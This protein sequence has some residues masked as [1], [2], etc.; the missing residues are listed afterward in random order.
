[1]TPRILLLLA[2]VLLVLPQTGLGKGPTVQL[3]IAGAHSEEPIH[4]K[5][6]VAI[7][8]WVWGD[9]FFDQDGGPV[10]R[11]DNPEDQLTIHFWVGLPDDSVEMKYVVWYTWLRQEQH[12][13]VCF[14][15][16]RQSN[17]YRRNTFTILRKGVD[18]TDDDYLLI[19]LARCAVTT[20]VIFIYYRIFGFS[21]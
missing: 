17:W 10:P 14:P 9:D 12:A 3:S 1:M 15:G 19:V 18:Y 13:V 4:T 11:P 7:S 8:A 6:P 21:F 2:A 5:D 16:P 20:A